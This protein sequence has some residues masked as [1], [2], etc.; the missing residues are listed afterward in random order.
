MVIFYFLEFLRGLNI[1]VLFRIC[2]R[3]LLDMEIFV[4]FIILLSIIKII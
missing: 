3:E 1:D 2:R 4:N